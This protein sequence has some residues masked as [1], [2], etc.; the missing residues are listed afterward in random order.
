MPCDSV[1]DRRF[2]RAWRSLLPLPASGEREQHSSCVS[3]PRQAFEMRDHL[4]DM[5]DVGVF[6]MEIEEIDLMADERAVKGALLD[7]DA[8][9]CI[10]VSIDRARTNTAGGAFAADDEAL[11]AALAQMRNQ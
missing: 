7:D 3:A 4:F 2:R 6:V 5:H 11:H 9:E 1:T 8:V 10:G